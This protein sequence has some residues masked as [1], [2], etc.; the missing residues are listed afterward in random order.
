MFRVLPAV[1]AARDRKAANAVLNNWLAGLG[2]VAACEPCAKLDTSNLQIR[3]DLAWLDDQARLGAELSHNLRRV[4]ANRPADG[5]QFYI[6]LTAAIGNP[7]FLHESYYT[8][9]RNPDSGCQI[10]AAFRF[11]NIIAYWFPYRDVIGENWDKVLR[12][13]ISKIATAKT[14]ESYQQ[15][16]MAL[17]ARAHDTH[18]NL[19]SSLSARPPVGSCQIPVIMRFVQN[20]AVVAG[21][22]S[23]E[24]VR[25]NVLLPGDII[26]GLDGIPISQLVEKWAPY[27]AASNE[28]TR[29]RD[30]ARSMFRGACGEVSL[31]VLR[32]TQDLLLKVNRIALTES[33]ERAALGHD[34][35]GDSFRGPVSGLENSIFAHP[36][37]QR[38]GKPPRKSQIFKAW[39]HACKII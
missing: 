16:L 7:Q 21:Y 33:D 36:L 11:W 19:W 35:P 32:G 10:L 38:P 22:T 18:A 12:L 26:T 13:S 27:Y 2:T 3:P 5:R 17:V 9:I 23:A 6:S 15:Q 28:P 8:A 4:Y 29:Y 1:L 20:R 14:P 31:R 24:A 34:L 39:H 30:I 37:W 25:G